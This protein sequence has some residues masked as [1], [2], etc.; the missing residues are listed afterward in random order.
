MLGSFSKTG[1]GLFAKTWLKLLK[2]TK[3]SEETG[4]KT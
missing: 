4:D 1:G 2:S 3:P